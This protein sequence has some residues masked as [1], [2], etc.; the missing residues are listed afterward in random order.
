MSTI[1]ASELLHPGLLQGVT[2]LLAGA[3]AVGV[4]GSLGASVGAACAGL[5]ARVCECR[6]SSDAS[7]A[8][9][10]D[11]IEQ[12]TQEAVDHALADAGSI[13]LLVVDGAS[14]FARAHT[15]TQA[16]TA[17]G[18]SEGARAALRACLDVSW[19]VTRVV[20]NRAFLVGGGGGRVL[21]LAPPPDGGEYADAARAGLE[22][23]ARTLSIEWARHGVTAV[24][25]VPRAATVADTAAVGVAAG[26]AGEVAALAAYL[27]SPAGAYFSGCLLDLRG[28][29]GAGRGSRR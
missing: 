20:A 23:L 6:L 11:A 27:A 2:I 8:L 12:L 19:N 22:N 10:D 16:Q 9:E 7:L 29:A 14:L 15:Q 17:A 5:G 1:D 4:G 3:P 25:I 26:A 18:G 24:A 28:P 21:Y 13:A